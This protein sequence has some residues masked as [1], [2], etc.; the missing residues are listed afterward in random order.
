MIFEVYAILVGVAIV[1]SIVS[2]YSF[3]AQSEKQDEKQTFDKA[4]LPLV[5]AGFWIAVA[6]SSM[7]VEFY[8]PLFN[9]TSGVIELYQYRYY[10]TGLMYL[11]FLVGLIFL[12]KFVHAVIDYLYHAIR[13]GE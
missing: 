12:V 9:D 6:L 7:N 11:Y 5:T 13:G 8:T 3:R 4:I 2:I 10:D 1:F